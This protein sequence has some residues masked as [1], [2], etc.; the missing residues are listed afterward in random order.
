MSA[1]EGPF[2]PFPGLRPFEP[3]E[4]HL[5]FGR[6]KEID[7]LLR[8]LRTTRLVSV[9]GTSG[10]GKSSLVRSGLIPSLHSG[11]LV[12]AGSSWRI[13]IFRPGE[14]PIG[15]MAR[16]IALPDVLGT[17][18]ELAST[19]AVL[20][21]ATLRRGSLGLA[22]AARQAALPPGTNL[23][24]VVDQFEELFRFRHSRQVE[25]SRDEAVSF[26]KLLLEAA[27]QETWPI[28]IVLTMRS[29]FIGDC[30]E[31]PGLPEAVNAGQ[32]LVRRMTRAE[33]RSAIT[34]PAAVAGGAIAP[35]LVNRV[36]NDLGDDPDQLPLLQHALMRTWDH[37]QRQGRSDEPIDLGDYEAIGTLRAA[38]S[39]H[40]EE[41]FDD[42]S[43]PR[44]RQIARQI[45]Q[46]LTDTVSDQRG[47][48]RPTAVADLAA[49]CEASIGEVVE[50]VDIFRR[51]GRCFLMPPAPTALGPA[52]IVDLSHESLMRCWSRLMEWAEQE[53]SSANVYARLSQAAAWFA[54]GTAGLW[55]NPE[56]ELAQ[57]WQAETRPT[58]A[59]ARRYDARFDDAMSFLAQSAAERDRVEADRERERKRTLRATQW[60][61]AVLAVLLLA[62]VAAAYLAWR[63]ST[64][65]EANLRLAREA[66]DETLASADRDPA[67]VAADFAEMENFRR[68]LLQRTERFYAAFMSQEP[69]SLDVRQDLAAAHLRLGHISRMLERPLDAVAQ[70]QDTVTQF[71]QL[72]EANPNAEAYRRSLAD[73]YNW[74]GETLRPLAGRATEAEA[75]YD[76]ARDLQQE[77]VAGRPSDLSVQQA[78]ARTLYNRGILRAASARPRDPA[79]LAADQDFRE[80]IAILER[81]VAQG[82]TSL[83]SQELARAFNNR[84]G[85]LAQDATRLEEAR[86]LYERAVAID[87]ALLAKEPHNREF[88]MELATFSSNLADLLRERGDS[89]AALVRNAQALRLMNDL[90]RPAPSLSVS[91]ADVHTL[92]GAILETGEPPAAARAYGTALDVFSSLAT[93]GETYRLPL[94]HLRYGDLLVNLVRFAQRQR[95]TG[96][97]LLTRAIETYL[98]L[99]E[100]LQTD[101]RDRA[102]LTVL[103][104]HLG[105]AI[106][107]LPTRERSIVASR[108]EA[109]VRATASPGAGG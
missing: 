22:E 50:V 44:G 69:S 91:L 11:F 13:A 96:G 3:D 108:Y 64:R 37:W 74:L 40:A 36:L 54:E 49:I 29:D 32:Y 52:S 83:A 94:F 85:L 10:S 70:Y 28:Y 98:A 72:V 95:A 73:A 46:A 43:E 41:A 56:L 81:V 67:R 77:L 25:H 107:A 63:E 23:L 4:D 75:A 26:V 34:G 93:D 21:E 35:R 45:F 79:F 48:R 2:N 47:V 51:P 6:D 27:A 24:V 55:R 87:E 5:F 82:G 16:A 60:A 101:P 15:H 76:A 14:D 39:M 88:A 8:R 71:R 97:E 100:R 38:L 78:L 9:V 66:V 53:R 102:S 18:P 92:R 109:L 86:A 62:A 89:A 19:N 99:G 57:R 80:A 59:W 31:Y 12:G 58:S 42:T 106:A 1:N 68:D 103:V 30:M 61:A 65:A 20:I 17:D 90:A 105:P 7:E 33:L 104:Q 84:A